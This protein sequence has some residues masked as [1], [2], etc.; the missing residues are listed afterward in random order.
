MQVDPTRIAGVPLTRGWLIPQAI[1]PKLFWNHPVMSADEIR[2]RTQ[3][4]WDHF[5]SIRMI[6]K[7]SG[8]LRSVKGRMAFIL[9][10][11]LYRRMYADTGIATDS[12]RVAWS[13]RWARWLAKPTRR[14]F[15]GRPLPDLQVP[16][17]VEVTATLA[18]EAQ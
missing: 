11:K 4:V 17:R 13:T 12:A 18:H 14:L 16:P 10:S 6:W 7:R 1:R 9:V 5:Y 2:T 3:G 8:F 15:A